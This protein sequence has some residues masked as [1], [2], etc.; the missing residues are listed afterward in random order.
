MHPYTKGK[1][2]KFERFPPL[3]SFVIVAGAVCL[4]LAFP[5]VPVWAQALDP[6]DAAHAQ[7]V[8]WQAMTEFYQAHGM[9]NERFDYEEAVVVQARRRQAIADFDAADDMLNAHF[10]YEEAV[11]VQARRG[12][13]MA[14]AHQP[15]DVVNTIVAAVEVL[16][17]R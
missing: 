15:L 13:A 12:Q 3:L 10:D 16:N 17:K 4:A 11:V 2:M 9:L 7:V 5:S 14:E 6:V 1:M 8:R